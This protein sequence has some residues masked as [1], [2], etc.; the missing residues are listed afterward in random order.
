[1]DDVDLA[2]RKPL[3]AKVGAK[4]LAFGK[5]S[6]GKTKFL[7]SWP[8]VAAI[9]AEMGMSWY[10]GT[11]DG[12][13]LV[14]VS[15]TQS[16]K[17]MEDDAEEIGEAFEDLGVKTFAIDSVTKIKENLEETIMTIDEKREKRK[18]KDV[19]E[20]NL[21]IRSRGRIKYT[22]KRLQNVKIDLSAKGVNIV[23]IAQAKP[24]KKKI[25]DQFEIVGYEPDMQQGSEHD[26]D[27]VL[28]F[29]TEPDKTGALKYYARVEKDRLEVFKTG[30]VIEDPSYEM[31]KQKIEARDKNESLDINYSQESQETKEKYE[32]EADLDTASWT[33]ALSALSKKLDTDKQKELAQMLKSARISLA[34]MDNLSPVQKDK[35]REIIKRFK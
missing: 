6:T 14:L 17:E 34:D 10:E 18:G 32:Q 9:D 5:K 3:E 33:E 8:G 27:I 16:F 29:Y 19:D 12:K 20:T 4:A 15:N 2:F 1:M 22:N 31:W 24:I 11:E 35:L 26:Y 21:S 25:G 23:D 7:L 28:F 13:N 30:D